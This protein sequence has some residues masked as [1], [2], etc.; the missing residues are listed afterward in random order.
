M[1]I[2]AINV[3]N[4]SNV[5]DMKCNNNGNSVIIIIIVIIIIVNYTLRMELN[6]DKY[7]T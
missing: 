1:L 7:G 3:G 2:Y 4:N 6:S 5:T